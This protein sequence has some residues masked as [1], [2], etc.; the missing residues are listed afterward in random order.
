MLILS[1]E[2]SKTCALFPYK[3]QKPIT[4]YFKN[5]NYNKHSLKVQ[6]LSYGATS[7]LGVVGLIFASGPCVKFRVLWE[8][9]L[10][11]KQQLVSVYLLKLKQAVNTLY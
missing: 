5:A 9:R 7:A 4:T 8:K 1:A 6:A 3:S 10:N 2:V 11:T